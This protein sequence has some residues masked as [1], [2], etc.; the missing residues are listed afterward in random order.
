MTGREGS[1]YE[2]ELT[3]TSVNQGDGRSSHN[4][5]KLGRALPDPLLN[6]EH[7]ANWSLGYSRVF[8]SRT[9]AQVELFRSDVRD[10][11]ENIIFPSPLRAARKGFCMQAVNIG[12]EVRQGGGCVRA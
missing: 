3:I 6:P 11:I 12:K 5:Y 4:S 10:A 1:L 7:A 2:A 9:V 8:A